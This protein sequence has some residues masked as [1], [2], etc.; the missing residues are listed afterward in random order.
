M[1]RKQ[2]NESEPNIELSSQPDQPAN[3]PVFVRPADQE[4]DFKNKL[5][6]GIG[7]LVILAILLVGSGW[8]SN[9]S[10]KINDWVAGLSTT[11]TSL[12]Q[13]VVNE[14]SLVID[15]VKKSGPS[16]VSI[17]ASQN[18]SNFFGRQDNQSRGIGSGFILSKDGLILTNKHVVSD[19]NTQY[20][21]VTNDGKK[22][23]VKQV[24]RDPAHDLAI[25]KIDANNL[26]PLEQGGF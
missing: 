1:P 22:Y 25:I 15:V 8:L 26:T 5:G 4:Q 23:D 21:V 7:I 6:L 13:K 9:L 10:D 17:G 11:R 16:V 20:S 12:N 24:Y 19:S 14:E 2:I 3:E 18:L